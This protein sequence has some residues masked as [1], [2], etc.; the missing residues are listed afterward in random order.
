MSL[1]FTYT[2][3]LSIQLRCLPRQ[4]NYFNAAAR[5]SR[6]ASTATNILSRLPGSNT[7]NSMKA[8]RTPDFDLEG[9]VI[10]VTG[11]GRGL[12]LTMAQALVEAGCKGKMFKDL[13]FSRVER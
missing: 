5:W 4:V 9:K 3:N 2:R 7:V 1:L 12:G 10:V 6:P 8:S 13:D 11:G